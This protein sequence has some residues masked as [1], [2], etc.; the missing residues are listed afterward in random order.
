VAAKLEEV[1]AKGEDAEAEHSGHEV[2]RSLADSIDA[3]LVRRL[4]CCGAVSL[5]CPPPV[6]P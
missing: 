6:S 2:Q 5:R 4:R 3:L 1:R